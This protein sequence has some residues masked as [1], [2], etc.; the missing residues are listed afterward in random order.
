M[1]AIVFPTTP[2]R[3]RDIGQDDY[4]ELNGKPASTFGTY[5]RNTE[6][7]SVLGV[8]GISMPSSRTGDLPI[9]IEFDGLAGE[10]CELLALAGVMENNE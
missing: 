5:I 2:V 7:G 1:N 4:I 10:D 8:P 3:A 6:P 9:G